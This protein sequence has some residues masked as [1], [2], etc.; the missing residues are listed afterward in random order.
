MAENEKETKPSDPN[1]WWKVLV[2][3]AGLAAIVVFTI[4]GINWATGL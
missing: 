3:F 2:V 1:G 4:A